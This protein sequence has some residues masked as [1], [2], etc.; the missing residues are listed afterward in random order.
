MNE[1]E[2]EHLIFSKIQVIMA[3]KRTSLAALRTAIA[4]LVLPLSVLS[5]LIATSKFYDTIQVMHLMI[6]LLAISAGLI[7]VGVYL[8]IRSILQ[9]RRLDRHVKALKEQYNFIKEI[10]ED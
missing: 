9:I 1:N 2:T 5:V 3:E 8:V 7:L 6:P 10:I 4:L